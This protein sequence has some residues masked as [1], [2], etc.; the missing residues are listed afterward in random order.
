MSDE[1]LQIV[2]VI[3]GYPYYSNKQL[4]ELFSCS[5]ATVCSRKKGIQRERERYGNYAVISS[6][7]NVYAYIDY[8]RYHKELGDRNMRKY[9]PAF[10]P[11]EIAEMC[12]FGTNLHNSKSKSGPAKAEPAKTKITKYTTI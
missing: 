6:G 10:N 12:G 1:K 5:P 8:D 3:H 9:V 7:T 4:A 11:R 2:E